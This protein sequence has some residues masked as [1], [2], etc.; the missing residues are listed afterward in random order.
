MIDITIEKAKLYDIAFHEFF[1]NNLTFLGFCRLTDR[2]RF[3]I[4]DNDGALLDISGNLSSLLEDTVEDPA[5]LA[6][7]NSTAG[8]QGTHRY[9][10]LEQAL[11]QIHLLHSRV[12]DLLNILQKNG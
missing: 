2:A 10:S 12:T 9:I 6:E 8:Q 5:L 3:L 11:P 4:D 7:L 1:S